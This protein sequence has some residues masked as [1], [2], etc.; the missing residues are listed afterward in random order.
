MKIRICLLCAAAFL[1]G[2]ASVFGALLPEKSFGNDSRGLTSASF[3]KTPPSARFEGLAG[4]CLTQNGP[5]SFFCNP[6]GLAYA[7]KGL[8]SASLDYESLLEGSYRTGASLVRGS[9]YGA[10]AAGALYNNSSPGMGKYNAMGDPLGGFPAYDSALGAAFAHRYGLT[11]FGFGVKFIKSKLAEAS[12]AS[13]AFDAGLIFREQGRAKTEFSL[14]VRNVGAPLRLG[15]ERAPLPLELGGGLKRKYTP[16]FDI[17]LEGRLPCD[18][19]PYMIIAGEW[20]LVFTPPSSSAVGKERQAGVSAADSARGPRQAGVSGLVVRGGVNF[21][22]YSDLGALGTFAGGFGLKLGALEFDYAFVP[23]G[24]LGSTHRTEISWRFSGVKTAKAADQKPVSENATIVVAPFEN[25]TG[26]T[27]TQAEVFRNL[28]EAELVLT[29]AFEI[30]ERQKLDFILA[31]K[32]IAYAGFSEDSAAGELGRL[33]GAELAVSGIV[34]KEAEKYLFTAKV[35]E[36]S[37]GKILRSA[38]TGADEEYFFRQAARE[39]VAD[40]FSTGDT[41]SDPQSRPAP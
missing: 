9:R 5:Q 17:L 28:F 25:G 26:V 40:L 11:D 36:V 4:A 19:S 27:E 8:V 22:N 24:E 20:F 16:N 39:L 30:I 3:L 10:F 6:A 32:K 13:V 35:V 1:S 12:A 2:R 34:S 21:K 41:E 23:Y 31:E 18:H 38:K 15:S 29:D 14:A 37:S 33:A 7:P